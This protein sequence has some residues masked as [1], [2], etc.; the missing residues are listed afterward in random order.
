MLMPLPSLLLFLY[1]ASVAA[2]PAAPLMLPVVLLPVKKY[3]MKMRRPK[4]KSP[5]A[6][7]STATPMKMR[8][9]PTTFPTSMSDALLCF[10]FPFWRLLI[11][12]RMKRSHVLI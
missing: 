8:T 11:K 1:L 3:S 4:K 9:P 12:G 7:R 6:T 10:S 2:R 5:R